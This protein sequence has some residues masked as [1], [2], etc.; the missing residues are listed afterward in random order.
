MNNS[1]P[2]SQWCPGH[3]QHRVN[4]ECLG[5]MLF[6][7]L[8]YSVS[9]VC[10]SQLSVPVTNTRDNQPTKKEGFIWRMDSE[11]SVNGSLPD[12]LAFRPV[13]RPFIMMGLHSGM[14]C[15]PHE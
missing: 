12:H 1:W 10:A 7:F 5:A 11:V 2:C 4:T 3:A 9:F 6:L 15:S 13:V 14:S 8:L